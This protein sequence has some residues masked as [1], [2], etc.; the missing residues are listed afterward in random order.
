MSSTRTDIRVVRQL[1]MHINV[2]GPAGHSLIVEYVL[3]K[4]K[5]NRTKRNCFF[6]LMDNTE[7]SSVFGTRFIYMRLELCSRGVRIYYTFC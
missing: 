3:S 1:Y 4:Y 7:R 6:F 5:I 2:I